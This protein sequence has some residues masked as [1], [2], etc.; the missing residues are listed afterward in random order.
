MFEIMSKY[1][2][3]M[4]I[5]VNYA[6]VMIAGRRVRQRIIENPSL[7]PGYEKIKRIHLGA[8]S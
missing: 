6:N 5:L 4:F 7:Q 3:L 8:G 1:F 2:W